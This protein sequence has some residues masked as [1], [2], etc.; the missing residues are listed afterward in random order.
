MCWVSLRMIFRV[1]YNANAPLCYFE[2]WC[3]LSFVVFL[4]LRRYADWPQLA[5]QIR[6]RQALFRPLFLGPSPCGASSAV[7]KGGCWV[8]QSAAKCCCCSG[9]QTSDQ[10]NWAT[11]MQSSDSFS[12]SSYLS[13]SPFLH[14]CKFFSLLSVLNASGRHQLACTSST[15][16]Y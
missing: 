10:Y 12:T 14:H 5:N 11:Y 13:F 16:L 7:S 6:V 8:T 9:Q 4:L 2:A 15:F 3:L 1:Q